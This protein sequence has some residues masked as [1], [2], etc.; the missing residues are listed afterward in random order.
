[1]KISG[2][3]NKSI[4]WHEN[5]KIKRKSSKSFSSSMDM[6]NHQHSKYQLRKMIDKIKTAGNRLKNQQ[7]QTHINEYKNIIKEYLSY[8]LR[9]YYILKKERSVDYSTLYTR[10]EIIDKEIE[11][12]TMEL[13]SDQSENLSIVARIDKIEGLLLDLYQ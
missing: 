7:T 3:D 11:Q 12:L 9:N 2:S 13:L 6:A 4:L 8:I 10:I 1:M 5:A